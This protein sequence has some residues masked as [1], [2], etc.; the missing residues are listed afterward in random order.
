MTF[1]KEKLNK[2]YPKTYTQV[3]LCM[4]SFWKNYQL[5]FILVML[6]VIYNY[7]IKLRLIYGE[8]NPL[9]DRICGV[10]HGVFIKMTAFY[11]LLINVQWPLLLK[12]EKVFLAKRSLLSD[13][14]ELV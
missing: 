2:N 9:W 3:S 10:V 14:M 13:P 4:I 11:C 5:L 7:I 6:M 12:K 1:R 8:E